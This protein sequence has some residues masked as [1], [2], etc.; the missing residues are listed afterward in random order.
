MEKTQQN[1]F[2]ILYYPIYKR[3]NITIKDI[4]SSQICKFNWVEQI[5]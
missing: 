3:N 4:N 5:R 1:V 2:S